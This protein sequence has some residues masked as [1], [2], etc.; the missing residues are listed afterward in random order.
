MSITL[1]A[2][3]RNPYTET[4]IAMSL[5]SVPGHHTVVDGE[6]AIDVNM[7][8][9]ADA[10]K[11][12]IFDVV[13]AGDTEEVR[14]VVDFGGGTSWFACTSANADDGGYAIRITVQG[15]RQGTDWLPIGT[16]AVLHL[17]DIPPD[18]RPGVALA[19]GDPLGVA[20]DKFD[21]N[22]CSG[23]PHLHLEVASRDGLPFAHVTSVDEPIS[24]TS[25]L[26]SLTRV[27]D[28]ESE[29]DR[30]PAP[31]PLAQN[32]TQHYANHNL[33]LPGVA[34]RAE[35]YAALGLGPAADYR[36]TAEQ[37]VALLAVLARRGIAPTSADGLSP[38]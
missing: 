36:G 26:F 22:G 38:E 12:V 37:N 11:P 25:V 34:V 28:G 8:G 5:S 31:L 6:V 21:S 10:G 32:L 23:G 2:D 20:T 17:K 9:M 33:T 35:I 24:A 3:V 13:P 27:V 29:P 15:R 14:G 30:R 4:N 18:L 19:P 7:P 1:K 16:V